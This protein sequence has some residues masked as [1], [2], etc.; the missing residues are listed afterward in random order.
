MEFRP[1]GYTPSGFIMCF[2]VAALVELLIAMTKSWEEERN[3]VF[4]Y[5]QVK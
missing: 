1:N 4:L 3:K 5:D 2:H